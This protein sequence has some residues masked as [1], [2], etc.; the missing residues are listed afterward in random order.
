MIIQRY[1]KAHSKDREPTELAAP[2]GDTKLINGE[3]ARSL[4]MTYFDTRNSK[5]YPNIAV[6]KLSGI[7]DKCYPDSGYA[8]PCIPQCYST[9]QKVRVLW[10]SPALLQTVFDCQ[11][12]GNLSL[13]G[14]RWGCGG[15]IGGG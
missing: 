6:K 14:L 10:S 5:H 13:T 4:N 3:V 7:C 8:Q 12:R 15:I 2:A 11:W 1:S 9:V